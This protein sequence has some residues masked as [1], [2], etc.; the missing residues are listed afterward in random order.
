MKKCIKCGSHAFNLYAEEIDQGGFCDV[1]Y[2][3]GRAHRAEAQLEQAASITKEARGTL[4]LHSGW[5]DLPDGTKFYT[6]P[7][8]RPWVGLTDE[9]CIT[10]MFDMGHYS[11]QIVFKSRKNADEFK[12][13]LKEKNT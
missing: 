13:A 9:F 11:L 6:T 7:Q 10:N 1:H 8:K 12:A 4:I 2:W 5:D 3:K